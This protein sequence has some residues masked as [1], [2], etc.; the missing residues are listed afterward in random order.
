MYENTLFI[1]VGTTVVHCSGT[2]YTSVRDGWWSLR[3]LVRRGGEG[4]RYGTARGDGEEEMKRGERGLLEARY[5]DFPVT[6]LH[7]RS[8]TTTTTTTTA[9]TGTHAPAHQVHQPTPVAPY[10]RSLRTRRRRK[11]PTRM[12]QALQLPIQLTTPSPVFAPRERV[13]DRNVMPD[14]DLVLYIR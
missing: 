1:D 14:N 11:Q 12:V 8:S 13:R 4:G 5:P 3:W 6:P 7:L 10:S 9:R 2:G